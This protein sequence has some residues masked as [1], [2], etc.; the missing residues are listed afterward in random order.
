MTTQR[1]LHIR[2]AYPIVTRDGS[3]LQRL[4]AA[5]KVV[6]WDGFP[7]ATKAIYRAIAACYPGIQLHACGSRVKGY[8]ADPGD[9]EA[10][11]AREA[12]GWRPGKFSD[13]DFIAPR[14]AEPVRPLPPL[15]NRS[16]ASIL[17]TSTIPIPVH[18]G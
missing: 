4:V 15:A 1:A 11:Q 8:Y 5:R 13:F 16:M 6:H 18:H 7:E 14:G 2:A 3:G 9:T 12:A 10:V 17:Y